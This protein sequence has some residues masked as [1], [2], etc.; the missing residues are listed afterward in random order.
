MSETKWITDI[1]LDLVRGALDVLDD[2]VEK[3]DLLEVPIVIS[4]YV[5]NMGA[6][7][8]DNVRERKMASLRMLKKRGVI[9]HAQYGTFVKEDGRLETGIGI[10]GDEA[11]VRE[12]HRLLRDRLDGR[13]SA[14]AQRPAPAPKG[15]GQVFIVCGRD[16][17]AT[18]A[19][20]RFLER[21]GIVP[22]I[23]AE[24]ANQG[25]TII[26]KLEHH[27][28]NDYAVVI[29]TP[30]DEGRLRGADAPLVPRARQNVVGELFYFTAKLGRGRV[31]AL[32]KGDMELPSDYNGFGYTLMDD[33]GGWRLKL[34]KEMKEAGVKADYTKVV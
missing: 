29:L 25:R 4:P 26:E 8:E 5:A 11:I 12:T 30:D 7:Q 9:R 14:P 33:S 2:I 27:A 20:A 28:E 18:Q 1:S 21:L 16:D 24:Q 31:C 10:D 34:A 6:G 23:L 15:K 3:M 22:V 19:V 32:K 17:A 13:A